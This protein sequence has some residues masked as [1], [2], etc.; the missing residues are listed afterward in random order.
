MPQVTSKILDTFTKQVR[1][2]TSSYDTIYTAFSGGQKTPKIESL[3]AT[4]KNQYQKQKEN[5]M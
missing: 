5:E 3:K 2:K 1:Q 4:F